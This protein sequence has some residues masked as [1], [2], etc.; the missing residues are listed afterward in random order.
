MGGFI[1]EELELVPDWSGEDRSLMLD[2]STSAVESLD[3]KVDVESF[4]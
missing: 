4:G 2:E 1:L 3:I